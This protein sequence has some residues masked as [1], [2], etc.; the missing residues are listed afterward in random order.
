MA[1]ILAERASLDTR[2]VPLRVPTVE[3]L[4]EE[5]AARAWKVIPPEG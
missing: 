1:T 4:S 2:P 5:T 3:R